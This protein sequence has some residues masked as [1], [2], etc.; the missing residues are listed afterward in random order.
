MKGHQ[1][2]WRKTAAGLLAVLLLGSV[3]ACT[4]TPGE[5]T[6]KPS[7]PSSP[8]NATVSEAPKET[9]KTSVTIKVLHQ[10]TTNFPEDNPVKAE[11]IKRTGIDFQP[12]TVEGGEIQNK[13]NVMIASGDMPDIIQFDSVKLKEL[14]DNKVIIPLD[15][16]LQQHGKSILDNKK[17]YFGKNA[18]L[19][20][21]VYALPM[22]LGY[23]SVL[24]L[25][26]DWLSK[27][28]MNLP[29]TL[30][31]YYNVLKAFVEKDP[32]GNGKNDT[33]GLG[34]TLEQTITLNHIFAAYGVA[35]G[36]PGRP[37]YVNG[38][39]L[40]TPLQPGYL[41]AVK[42]LNKLYKEG[43]LDPD[44]PTIPA[45]KSFEKLWNGTIGVY[46]FTPVGTSNNWV[47]RYKDPKPE[48]AF[49]VLKGPQG[50]GGTARVIR[51]TGTFFGITRASKHP[52][53]AMKLLNFLNSEEGDK[54][55]YLGIE[56]KH[57]TMK[58]GKVEWIPPYQ[59]AAKQRNEGGFAYSAIS[60]R[61]GGA[62]QIMLNKPTQDAIKLGNDNAMNDGYIY[63]R[64]VVE[65][66]IG[67]ILNDIEKEM[68]VTLVA[69]KG[70]LDD[71]YEKFKKKYLDAGGKKWIEQATAIYKKENKVN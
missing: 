68:L 69:S 6:A 40:P 70:N 3:T 22:G 13:L 62:E 19:D 29:T 28:A 26:K 24:A 33:L 34:A 5:N 8:A 71:E 64:P 15:E 9:P 54:L 38:E 57:Y 49:T 10:R 50:K 16:L 46:D 20:G 18:T 43:L 12:I 51:D 37:Q 61:I 59:D 25:R 31:E 60:Y 67:K 55:T 23:P 42:F 47:S 44:F 14:V 52:E 53:E 63:E 66:E 2:A 48:W 27:V 21:K 1:S 39:L 35:F 65:V 17:A 41:D 11:I 45:M 32:D 58:D 7:S 56:G 4:S 36:I 30:D